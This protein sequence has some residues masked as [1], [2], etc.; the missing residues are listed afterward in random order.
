MDIHIGSA[1]KK[2]VYANGTSISGFAETLGLKEGSV[3]R[4]FRYP[5][6]HTALLK[7]ISTELKYDFFA[8]YSKDLNLVKE[9]IK[10]S[11]G[12]KL[13]FEKLLGEQKMELDYLRKEVVYLKQINDLLMRK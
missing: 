5:S 4:L 3:S 8:I 13:G 11:D 6:V 9:E 12:E 2:V 10:I 7:T 1:I